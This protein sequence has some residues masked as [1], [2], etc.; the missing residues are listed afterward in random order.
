MV[1]T[2]NNKGLNRFKLQPFNQLIPIELSKYDSWII[3]EALNNCIAHQDYTQNARVIVTEKVD[4]LI[5]QNRGSFY[6]GNV[7]DYV[8]RER[9]PEKYR[10]PFLTQAMVNMDMIELTLKVGL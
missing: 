3:L 5:L 10:N 6:D 9:T 8:L 4:K 2:I 7:E 1:L